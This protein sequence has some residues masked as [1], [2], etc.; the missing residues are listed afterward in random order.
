MHKFFTKHIYSLIFI[1]LIGSF[2]G[3]CSNNEEKTT[4][5]KPKKDSIISLKESVVNT[6]QS[7]LLRIILSPQGG[8]FRGFSIGDAITKIKAQETFEMFEDSTD[9]VGYTYET[10]NFEAIDVLY[11]LDKNKTLS[12]IRVEV[13]LNDANAVRNL[14]EQFETYLSGKYTVDKKIDKSAYWKGKGEIKILLEDVSKGKDYGL[15][16]AIGAKT[17]KA[18]P[19]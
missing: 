5:Q 17:S 6:N 10:E 8:D 7:E 15:R 1:A 9:H 13:Y 16:L 18:M 2:L 19:L 12:S 11:F 14:Q 4:E 3:S